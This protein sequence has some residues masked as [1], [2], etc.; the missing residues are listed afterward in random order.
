MIFSR[1]IYYPFFTHLLQNIFFENALLK[2]YHTKHH[3]HKL[4]I[5]LSFKKTNFIDSCSKLPL[6]KIVKRK[7][8]KPSGYHNSGQTKLIVLRSRS[9]ARL[10]WTRGLCQ[11]RI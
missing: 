2:N 9:L 8:V 1:K 7:P 6:L 5:V 11:K 3:E 4:L 10:N